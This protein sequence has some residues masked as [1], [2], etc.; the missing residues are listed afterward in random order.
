MRPAVST[1][2]FDIVPDVDT[3]VTRIKGQ[4]PVGKRLDLLGSQEPQG[5]PGWLVRLASEHLR[6]MFGIGSSTGFLLVNCTSQFVL[7]TM[8]RKE[9]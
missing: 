4:M 9:D 6:A 5:W 3:I 1:F 8:S 2:G 7:E